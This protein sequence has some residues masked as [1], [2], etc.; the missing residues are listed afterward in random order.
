MAVSEYSVTR[1]DVGI[2]GPVGQPGPPGVTSASAETLP[3]GSRAS[4]TLSGQR[5]VVGVPKGDKGD[6]GD[7]GEAATIE[8]GAV[9]T[10]APGR[11]ATVTNTGTP[12]A[13][14][15][16]FGIPRGDGLRLKAVASV[17]SGL[18]TTG[19]DVGDAAMADGVLYVWDGS[20]WLDQG[21]PTVSGRDGI[22][23]FKGP[24]D[25]AAV[26][27]NDVRTGDLWMVTPA[28][29][30]VLSND[31][32]T[33]ESTYY[34]YS[35]GEP[36]NSPSVLVTVDSIVTGLYERDGDVWSP[37]FWH[38]GREPGYVTD[39]TDTDAG[40][41]AAAPTA[42]PEIVELRTR[43]DALEAIVSTLNGQG[44]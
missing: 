26:D 38:V 6:K 32:G 33:R 29:V 25:P 19:L 42:S 15:L 14:V 28:S 40:R 4:A 10:L 30:T 16:D 18:P 44:K 39:S 12:S 17:Q 41:S 21:R 13:A 37:L 27:G 8:V 36:G 11:P 5:L 23:V 1:K 31:G 24:D 7:R 43:V 3:A 2:A 34:T 22:R 35:Q 9:T 20:S